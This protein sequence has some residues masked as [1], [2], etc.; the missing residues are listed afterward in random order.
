MLSIRSPRD[1]SDRWGEAEALRSLGASER[2][3]WHAMRSPKR[4]REWLLS[5]L[6][7]KELCRRF[8]QL[9]WSFEPEFAAMQV[10][11]HPSGRPDLRVAW[12]SG[13]ESAPA[14][15]LS[16]AHRGDYAAVAL[17]LAQPGVG[18]GIDVERVEPRYPFFAEHR[19][20]DAEKQWLRTQS[21]LDA[22][23]ALT[24]LWALKEATAKALGAS[25]FAAWDWIEV[26]AASIA[27]ESEVAVAPPL[28]CAASSRTPGAAPH[29]VRARVWPFDGYAMAFATTWSAPAK[30]PAKAMRLEEKP[31]LPRDRQ[32]APS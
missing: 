14:W 5:R 16:I 24:A 9:H 26:R 21:L 28:D 12:P 13:F 19:Y 31:V 25:L 30:P 32:G 15:A 22:D 1:F 27:D 6:T 10:V 2:A 8:C 4:R 7:A 23:G 11:H 29:T 17:Q 20:T 18:I 3:E